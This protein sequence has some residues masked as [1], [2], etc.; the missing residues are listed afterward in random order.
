MKRRWKEVVVVSALTIALVAE[1]QTAISGTEIESE[2]VSVDAEPTQ[3]F[4]VP[5]SEELQMRIFEECEK[6][7][8]AP[9]VVVAIIEQESR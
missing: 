1:S 3:F 8:I 5:L 2:I 4:A 6:H 9:A 7:N